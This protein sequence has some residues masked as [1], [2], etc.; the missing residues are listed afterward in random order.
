MNQSDA[1]GHTPV[2]QQYLRIKAQY[3]DALLFYRMGDFY[4]LFY[5]DARRAARLL[6]ITLT[7]RGHSGGEPIPMAGV[8]VVS[9]DTYLARAVRRGESVAICEQVGDPAKSKGPVA[10]EVVRVVT[11]GTLTEDALLEARRDS[12]L[13]ALARSGERFGLAWVELSSGRFAVLEAEGAEALAA[14][15]ERLRPAE[16]LHADSD[17]APAIAGAVRVRPPWHFDADSAARALCTQFD[18]HD[19]AGFGMD[20]LGLATGAAGALAPVPSRHAEIGAAAPAGDPGRVPHRCA[21]ARRGDPPQPRD[22]REPVRPRGRDAVRGARSQRD[23]DGQSR[24]APLAATPA[25]GAAA[26][27]AAAAGDRVAAGIRS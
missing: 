2:M 22:R 24:A 21:A 26:A 25:A 14:E 7:A 17:P 20:G 8:P 19:L 9:V 18:T 6:D 15:L 12:L 5:E 10:R 13:A 11:P 27:R 1:S 3:P 23:G 16:L 4:E